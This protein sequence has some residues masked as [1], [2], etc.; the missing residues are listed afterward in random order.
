MYVA[1][2]SLRGIYDWYMARSYIGRTLTAGTK[3]KGLVTPQGAGGLT[4][5]SHG[6]SAG[7]GFVQG[8]NFQIISLSSF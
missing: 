1:Y 8:F 6:R 4:K 2:P 5:L 3:G 7:E